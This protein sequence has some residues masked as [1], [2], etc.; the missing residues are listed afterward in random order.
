MPQYVSLL[1]F[2]EQKARTI[3]KSTERDHDLHKL[4]ANAGVKIESQYWPMG[5]SDGVLTLRADSEQQVLHLL[6][7]LVSLDHVHAGALQALVYSEAT[8]TLAPGTVSH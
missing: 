3:N 8:S 6:K 7:G 4:A 5:E 1:R 2:I